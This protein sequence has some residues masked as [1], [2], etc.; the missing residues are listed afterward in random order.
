MMPVIA[1]SSAKSVFGRFEGILEETGCRICEAEAGRLVFRGDDG[2]GYYLCGKCGVMYASPRFTEESMVTIYENEAFADLS[3]YN[4]WSYET[5]K[6]AGSRIFHTT[7]QKVALLKRYLPEGSRVLDVGCG[8]GI[9]VLEANR[10]NFVCEGVEPSVRL[11][12]IGLNVLKVRVTTGNV[13]TF[14]PGYRFNGIVIWD[15]LE[16]LYD[17]VRIV[18]RCTELLEPGGFLFA[19]VPNF[20]GLSNSYKTWLCRIGLKKV[21][22][23]FGFPWHVYSFD[24]R[25]LGYLIE[26]GG[27]NPLHFESWSHLLK[28]GKRGMIARTTIDIVRK[29]CMSDYIVCIARKPR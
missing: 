8:T 23:H 17:P 3:V 9:A 25:S 15:V 26:L 10:N 27:L 11:S 2:I 7:Q 4:N 13:E 29:F 5:W 1:D 18:K 19:Q 6:K 28:E 24:T 16:H 20:R 14:S 22:K 12:E 21:F